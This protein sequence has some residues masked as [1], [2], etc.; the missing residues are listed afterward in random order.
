MSKK[1]ID[2]IKVQGLGNDFILL[3]ERDQIFFEPNLKMIQK[4][5]DRHKGIGADGILSIRMGKHGENPSEIWMRLWNADGSEAQMC[6]NGLRVIALYLK[7]R[8]FWQKW[9]A[10]N[11]PMAIHTLG[12]VYGVRL[13]S[14]LIAQVDQ[15]SQHTEQLLSEIQSLEL[16]GIEMGKPK[17]FEPR[18][19]HDGSRLASLAFGNP[20]AVS[21]EK[22]AFENKDR[23]APIWYQAFEGGVNL[24]FAQIISAT[25]LNLNVYERGCGW[26]EACGTGACATVFNGVQEA[27]FPE[28]HLIKVNLPGGTLWVAVIDQMVEMWGDGVEIFEGQVDLFRF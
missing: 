6:G 13:S 1:M 10:Q 22:S 27:Y 24:S 3:D 26:T 2:F 23:L 14:P 8:G 25:E 28:N 4:L 12:G 21:F 17:V 16:V 5:C 15:N 19:M 20:H 7:R 9:Q 11:R 18:I